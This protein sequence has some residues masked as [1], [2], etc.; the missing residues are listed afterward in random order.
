MTG[1]LSRTPARAEPAPGSASTT[2]GGSNG[3]R[4]LALQ[5]QVGNAAVGRMLA[6]KPSHPMAKE[7]EVA[8]GLNDKGLIDF[9]D[10]SIELDLT[11]T[12]NKLRNQQLGYQRAVQ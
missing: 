1:A 11:K 3:A 2:S 8:E 12:D 6:R 4:M 9:V 10:Q 7:I 5:H